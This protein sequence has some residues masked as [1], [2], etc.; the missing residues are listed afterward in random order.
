MRLFAISAL[1]TMLPSLAFAH[2]NGVYV[3]NENADA[4][5]TFAVIGRCP[6]DVEGAMRGSLRTLTFSEV[7]QAEPYSFVTGNYVET[8]IGQQE[9]YV[10]TNEQCLPV[11][12]GER[13]EAT[14]TTIREYSL[15][16]ITR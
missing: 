5:V 2:R 3:I 16:R 10:Q 6:E 9:V 1:L 7:A 8:H 4:T 15:R 11:D 13:I 12:E 14:G